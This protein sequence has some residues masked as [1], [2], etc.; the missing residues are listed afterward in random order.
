MGMVLILLA[1]LTTTVSAADE[2]YARFTVLNESQHPFSITLYGGPSGLKTISV[3]PYSQKISFFIRGNYSFTMTACGATKSGKM[4]LT[5]HQTLH[6][7]V[8]G[9][10][11]GALG[12]QN[13]HIDEE[14]LVSCQIWQ[15]SNIDTPCL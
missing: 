6:V 4:D 13:H 14:R 12:D 11:A 2:Y 9:G 5:I 15:Y 10:T 7:P 8:C 3:S 1:V